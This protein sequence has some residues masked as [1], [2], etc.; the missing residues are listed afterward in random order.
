MLTCVVIP[1]FDHFEEFQQMLPGLVAQG[2]PLVVV[3]DGS[4]NQIYSALTRLLDEYAPG[5][6]LIRHADNLGKGEA[7]V[8]GL[9]FAL[10]AG[11]SHALQIDADGQH[12]TGAIALLVAAGNRH[13]DRIICAEPIFDESIPTIRYYARY[14]TL[15]FCWLEALSTEIRDAMCG[16]RLYPLQQVVALAEK[17]RLGKHM[18]FDS[19]AL[20]RA[21]WAGI[22]LE[23]I[24]VQVTYPEGGRSHFRMIKDNLEITWMHTRLVLGMILRLPKLLL[25][26]RSRR[27][28][29]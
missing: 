7:V 26:R 29:L 23:F 12:D 27:D 22:P 21:V 13:Q 17:S 2:L 15:Y 18:S 28:T 1:H 9:R 24:P 8:T 25:R 20:V 11:Y 19:E 16:F 5:S 6:I 3:D 14:I 10:D 4:S